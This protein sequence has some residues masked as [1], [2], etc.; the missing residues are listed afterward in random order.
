MVATIFAFP[1]GEGGCRRQTDEV[2]PP[3]K[4]EG[5][6]LRRWRGHPSGSNPLRFLSL[7]PALGAMGRDIRKYRVSS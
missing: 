2:L 4:G 1:S 7:T 3:L 5:D 6:R